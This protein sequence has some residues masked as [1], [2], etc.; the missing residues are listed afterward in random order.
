[1]VILVLVHSRTFCF[2]SD[3]LCFS[4]LGCIGNCSS[5]QV[6]EKWNEGGKVSTCSISTELFITVIFSCLLICFLF[7]HM[8]FSCFTHNCRS[9]KLHQVFNLDNDNGAEETPTLIDRKVEQ[10]FWSFF[11]VLIWIY[12]PSGFSNNIL[13]FGGKKGNGRR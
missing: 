3:L 5:S 9:F 13:I 2:I 10:C 12:F 6:K 8:I 7:S 11:L 4:W 1:M